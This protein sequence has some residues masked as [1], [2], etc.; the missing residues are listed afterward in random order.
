MNI[1]ISEEKLAKLVSKAQADGVRAAADMISPF[2]TV[3]VSK[4][5]LRQYA[6]RL[7]KGEKTLW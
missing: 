4:E 2:N 6:D 5:I 7:E 3:S 1:S